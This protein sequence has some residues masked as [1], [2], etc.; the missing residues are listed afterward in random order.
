M[1]VLMREARLRVGKTLWK[2]V[3]GE[4]P[5]NEEYSRWVDRVS[6]MCALGIFGQH[7]FQYLNPT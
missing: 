1:G 7:I 6:S 3:E 5:M 2:G 4:S